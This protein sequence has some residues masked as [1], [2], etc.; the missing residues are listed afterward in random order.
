MGFECCL[1]PDAAPPAFAAFPTQ[2]S[3]QNCLIAKHIA[4]SLPK[5]Q[6]LP[7]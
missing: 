4:A 5:T 1:N 6:I 2:G 7:N 3:F